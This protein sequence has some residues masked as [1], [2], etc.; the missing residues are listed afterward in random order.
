MAEVVAGRYVELLPCVLGEAAR[1]PGALQEEEGATPSSPS[2]TPR[3]RGPGSGQGSPRI[4]GLVPPFSPVG[5]LHPRGCAAGC[6]PVHLQATPAVGSL[7][8]PLLL[9]G[10]AP[11]A[12]VPGSP[13]LH[14]CLPGPALPASPLNPIYGS[15]P[16]MG[17]FA[18]GMAQAPCC[19]APYAPLVGQY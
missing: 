4:A 10:G 19:Q 9:A 16:N 5:L 18:Y 8:S 6:S 1:R 3:G 13:V 15:S 7:P 11:L 17:Y 14:S 12:A 2:S